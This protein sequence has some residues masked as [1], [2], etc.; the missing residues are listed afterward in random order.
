M[1]LCEE[2]VYELEEAGYLSLLF[3]LAAVQSP[4]IHR[5]WVKPWWVC[6]DHSS[7]SKLDCNLPGPLP[8]WILLWSLLLRISPYVCLHM[9]FPVLLITS[10]QSIGTTWHVFFLWEGL[11]EMKLE[12]NLPKMSLLRFSWMKAVHFN[13]RKEFLQSV[14][15]LICLMVCFF[16]GI[17]V[18]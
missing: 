14:T 12:I 4:S 8:T 1:L 7:S 18:N 3:S 11:D 9:C 13:F 5:A 15:T 10:L 2:L 17:N 16:S 6:A